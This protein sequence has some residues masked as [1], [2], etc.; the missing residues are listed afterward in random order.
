MNLK[1]MTDLV[2]AHDGLM[3]ANKAASILCLEYFS[4]SIGV[5]ALGKVER[6]FDVIYRNSKFFSLNG[7]IEEKRD[8]EGRSII[9]ILDLNISAEKRALMIMRPGKRLGKTIKA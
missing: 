8:D 4:E 1:D 5:G 2:T 9:D 3:E 7:D 6:L